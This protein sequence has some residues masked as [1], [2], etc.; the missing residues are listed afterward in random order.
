[1]II[2][3]THSTQIRIK[4]KCLDF[5]AELFIENGVEWVENC[6]LGR[7]RE[8]DIYCAGSQPG[9]QNKLEFGRFS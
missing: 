3:H 5:D 8:R 9:R 6:V 1:M 4:L 2:S 7:E